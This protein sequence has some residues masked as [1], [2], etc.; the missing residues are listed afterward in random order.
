MEQSQK[1][2][3]QYRKEQEAALVERF[4]RGD[5]SA[6][7]LI[8][9]KY[10]RGI[11]QAILKM[12]K[13]VHDAEDLTQDVLVKIYSRI[14]QWDGYHAFS[15]W[16]YRIAINHAIDFMRKKKLQAIQ[17]EYETEDGEIRFRGEKEEAEKHLLLD[18]K[19]I[20][21]E[22]LRNALM[23]LPDAQRELILRFYFEGRS[24]KELSKLFNIPL[25]T[26]KARLHRAKRLLERYLR[27]E[28]L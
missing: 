5:R 26:V 22:Q 11:F 25:G 2:R 4:K 24:Y 27:D 16:V 12:V 28:Q 3:I 17:L 15:T 7:A 6:F 19:T 21:A 20:D 23:R 13:N 18:L 14:H 9:K 8:V 1:R 10:Q